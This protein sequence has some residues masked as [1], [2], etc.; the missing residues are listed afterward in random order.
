MPRKKNTIFKSG[1]R[2]VTVSE[3]GAVEPPS[4]RGPPMPDAAFIDAA[5]LRARYG[6]RSHMWV[7]RLLER[8]Q[9]FPRP[10]KIG[11]LRFFSVAALTEWERKVAARAP[12]AP[13]QRP[14]GAPSSGS[15]N[16]ARS[17]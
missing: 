13:K 15:S 4:P 5:Q 1:K 8:D 12:N 7:V 3:S 16:T 2:I 14:I 17:A 11:R 6:N 9:T 10:V